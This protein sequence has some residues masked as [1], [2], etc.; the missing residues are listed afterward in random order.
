MKRVR[1]SV[2]WKEGLHM[3]PAARLVKRA[4]RF[5]SELRLKL[6]DNM[7]DLRSI[8][9]VVLLGAGCGAMLEV[10]AS[11][12][13]ENEAAEAIAAVFQDTE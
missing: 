4:M 7:A 13:D 6:G 11:G 10:E 8:V 3:R 9:A 2:P 5:R 12:H 1:V